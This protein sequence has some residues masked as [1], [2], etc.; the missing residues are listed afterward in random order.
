[1]LDSA[2]L[3]TSEFERK[4]GKVRSPAATQAQLGDLVTGIARWAGSVEAADPELV[5]RER[6]IERIMDEV[7]L[8]FDR[9]AMQQVLIASWEEGSRAPINLGRF[10]EDAAVKRDNA[11]LDEL[12]RTG[13]GAVASSKANIV[14]IFLNDPSWQG[15]LGFDTLL[16]RILFL[17]TAPTAVDLSLLEVIAEEDPNLQ[18]REHLPDAADFVLP[19]SPSHAASLGLISMWLQDHYGMHVDSKEMIGHSL[20][21]AAVF[22]R[23]NRLLDW[24]RSRKWDGTFRILPEDFL[25]A[26]ASG[27]APELPSRFAKLFNTDASYCAQVVTPFLRIF[28][29]SF[30]GRII[31]P[32][33]KVDTILILEGE[34]GTRK[35]TSMAALLPSAAYFSDA[36]LGDLDNKES[37]IVT[38]CLA[39]LEISEMDKLFLKRNA[40]E[41]KAWL[42]RRI[43][44]YRVPY[45]I[46]AADFP[47]T[48]VPYGTVNPKGAW[49][50]E[51][52]TQREYMP[53]RVDQL[54]DTDWIRENRDQIF[55]EALELL[56][57][58]YSI[59]PDAAETALIGQEMISRLVPD[60]LGQVIETELLRYGL[61]YIRPEDILETLLDSEKQQAAALGPAMS[62]AMRQLD[63]SYERKRIGGERLTGWHAPANWPAPPAGWNYLARPIKGRYAQ[64]PQI[65][66]PAGKIVPF[67]RR[68]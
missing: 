8:P 24:V 34:K 62:N 29:L 40:S 30:V 2:T 18:I 10:L 5:S 6:W 58:G 38:S 25:A 54:I 63:W 61:L 11:W 9:Q 7:R 49:L 15:V 16:K 31:K 26:Q 56:R 14:K 23:Q 64:G 35:S 66:D 67:T 60:A 20:L 55:A 32:G 4:L 41:L 19:P 52:G 22:R 39:L 48:F 33:C 68:S 50:R 57:M 46:E 65:P 17:K 13:S 12:L 47:R 21:T 43:D 59:F 1:M 27:A 45:G 28:L 51:Y 3:I 36:P 42:R 53:V 37:A 44:R